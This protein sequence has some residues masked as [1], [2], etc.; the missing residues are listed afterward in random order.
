MSW[1]P[2]PEDRS[3]WVK[4]SANNSIRSPKYVGIGRAP[5]SYA[6]SVSDNVLISSHAS[7]TGHL[8]IFGLAKL[9][10]SNY[11]FESDGRLSVPSIQFLSSSN[12]WS[13][14]GHLTFS[15]I[16]HGNGTGLTNVH[17]FEDH[18][19]SAQHLANL[20]IEN[21]NIIDESVEPIHMKLGIIATNNVATDQVSTDYIA[22]NAIEAKHILDRSIQSHHMR[23]N[24]ISSED[25]RLNTFNNEKYQADAIRTYHI[26]DGAIT[27]GKIMA[28]NI[29][30]R[31]LTSGAVTTAKIKNGTLTGDHV[32]L[33]SL[34]ITDFSGVF[35]IANG[36]TGQTSFQNNGV[37][38]S[39]SANQYQTDPSVL[40]IQNGQM[41]IGAMPETGV[42]LLVQRPSNSVMGVVADAAFESNIM[43]RN[44]S[45]TWTVRVNALG[46]LSFLSD[47]SPVLTFTVD[48]KLGIG[49]STPSEVLTLTGPL[50]VGG[51]KA[52]GATSEP[53]S[54][55]YDGGQFSVYTS[56]WQ[57]ITSGQL[58]KRLFHQSD[59][60]LANGSAI[61]HAK[62]SL[63]VGDS[64]MV[65]SVNDS[66]VTGQGVSVDGVNST[67]VFGA[68]AMAHQLLDSSIGLDGAEA[69]QING[70][71]GVMSNA[72]LVLANQ[73]TV[74]L[75]DASFVRINDSNIN[76]DYSYG[77]FV[78][79]SELDARFS[80]LDFL[81]N[82][83]LNA[84]G[85]SIGFMRDVAGSMNTSN[86]YFFSNVEAHL[87]SS[88]A[89]YVEGSFVNLQNSKVNHISNSN[90]LGQ[91]LIIFG[92][93]QHDVQSEGHLSLLGDRHHV[94]A[95]RGVAIGSDVHVQHDDAVLINASNQV[96]TSD[97]PGQ[98]KIQADGGVEIQ[99]SPG[100]GISMADSMGSWSNLSDESMKMSKLVVDPMRI[101]DKVRNLPV[102]YWQYK[103]QKNI[104]H[105][106]PTAQ[107]FHKLFQYGNSDKVIHSIDSDGVLLASI[108]GLSMSFDEIK[109][110]L[111]ED[112]KMLQR[113]S[114]EAD[115]L[116]DQL[117]QIKPRV[118]LME[119]QYAYNFRILDQFESDFEQQQGMIVYIQDHIARLRWEHYLMMIEERLMVLL[120]G[121]LV[122]GAGIFYDSSSEVAIMRIIF[123]AF[124]FIVMTFSVHPSTI[125]A[126]MEIVLSNSENSL[127]GQL[128]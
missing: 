71:K 52:T 53:G 70:S 59:Q 127:M 82:T 120:L 124:L 8:D 68:N 107:D 61:I 115:R 39:N 30:S 35:S 13:S 83:V 97:R 73:A 86:A 20:S 93:E 17:H 1:I 103:S 87:L 44:S 67:D 89:R 113:H 109:R 6:L 41:G 95:N 23:K 74:Q 32:P 72:S 78:D 77:N 27:G 28:Q 58:S 55:K 38:Y 90:I 26:V 79:S 69:S 16:L 100:M 105:I 122:L 75:S 117:H 102:Q 106:G 108:K 57:S 5:N 66:S 4:D 110:L 14:A 21:D 49:T 9:S 36:G 111:S 88:D 121:G 48:G 94:N 98:L 29:V 119:Q 51:S 112:Q 76:A 91:G 80:M 18:S 128:I 42:Q 85:A 47:A 40:S 92:G 22:D 10:P 99:F 31:H 123:A 3:K 43:L 37:L 114:I 2:D 56:S 45:S 19:F 54:I 11:G 81:D 84:N 24:E 15:G 7:F 33:N 104:Q 50:V 12:D 96:L 125:T 25:I 60:H 62:D 34:P 65:Y 116:I 118:D 101:L 63:L 64:L 46:A 126:H